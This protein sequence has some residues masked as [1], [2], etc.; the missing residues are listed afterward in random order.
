MLPILCNT[1]AID[2]GLYYNEYQTSRQSFNKFGLRF[3]HDCNRSHRRGSVRLP[4]H[5]S[6]GILDPFSRQEGLNRQPCAEKRP[7]P[8]IVE[9]E[10]LFNDYGSVWL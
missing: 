6:N 4:N 2:H 10:S 3:K 1:S 7:R 9:K 5:H 8:A